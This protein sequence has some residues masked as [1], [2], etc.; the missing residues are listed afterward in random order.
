MSL[1]STKIALCLE[2][3][4]KHDIVFLR[5]FCTHAI[6]LLWLDVSEVVMFNLLFGQYVNSL[7]EFTW[8]V[9]VQEVF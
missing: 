8:V 9:S 1:V 5:R 4:S 7:D 3:D 2:L 6:P